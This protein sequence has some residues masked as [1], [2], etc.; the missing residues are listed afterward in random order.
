[1]LV[2]LECFRRESH[3]MDSGRIPYHGQINQNCHFIIIWLAEYVCECQPKINDISEVVPSTWNK[4]LLETIVRLDSLPIPLHH[5]L[6]HCAFFMHS[7]Y[8]VFLNVQQVCFCQGET[9]FNGSCQVFCR[10]SINNS[11]VS[12]MIT[13]AI[14]STTAIYE[15]IKEQGSWGNFFMADR[16]KWFQENAYE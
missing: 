16:H 6:M 13:F 14:T 8:V 10:K 5:T 3:F 4:C 2:P 7:R 11:T 9:N 12:L 15:A 1:M